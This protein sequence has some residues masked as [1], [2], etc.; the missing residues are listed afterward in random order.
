MIEKENEEKLRYLKK[1]KQISNISRN[2]RT[3]QI[4]EEAF[5]PNRSF[6]TPRLLFN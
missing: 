5:S 6:L 3:L 4:E 2:L 1:G